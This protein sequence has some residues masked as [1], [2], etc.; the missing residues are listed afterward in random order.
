VHDGRYRVLDWGDAVI[1][2]P[3]ASLVV[4]FRFL[5]HRTRLAPDD[6]WFVRLR[7]AYLEPW[8]PGLA[9]AA[10]LALRVGSVARAFAYT[11][12]RAALPPES[13]AD[14]DVDLAIVLR[15]TLAQLRV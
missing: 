8:G 2:H 1:S 4:N 9:G 7:D 5:E 14:F 3:F 11:R 6:A 13:H 10:A 15:R 12:V